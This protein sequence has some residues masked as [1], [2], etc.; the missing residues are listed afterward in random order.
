MLFLY[1]LLT[2][3]VAII[4]AEIVFNYGLGDKVKDLFL[5]IVHSAEEVKQN[6]IQ[7]LHAR[8]AALEA[9]V[10]KVKAAL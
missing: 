5:G 10:A 4:V 2:A 1:G 9:R 6:A 7:R 8:A 3:T